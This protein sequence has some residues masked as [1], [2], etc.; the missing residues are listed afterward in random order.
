MGSRI[1]VLPLHVANK[2]AA[3]EVVDRPAS[4]VKELIENAVD[5]GATR[6]EVELEGGGRTRVS[7]T[8]NGAGMGRDDALLSIERQATSKIRD[9]DDIERIATLGFRGEALAAI[10]SVSRFRLVTR[11][12]AS[13]TATELR[14]SGGTLHDVM[15]AGGPVGTTV[16]VRDLFFNIPA[17]RKFLRSVQ[18]EQSHARHAFIL[19]ALARP[20]RAFTLTA[21]GQRAFDLPAGTRED[22]IRDLFGPDYLG[23][24]RPIETATGTI[25]VAGYAGLPSYARADRQEQYGFIN[26]RAAAAPVI[27]FAIREAY[28]GAMAKDKH[29]AVFLYITLDPAQVD[30]NVHPT[31]REV[32][33]RRPGDVRDAVLDALRAA[34]RLP[35][36][37]PAAQAEPM[38]L[39][40]SAVQARLRIDDLPE[41]RPF[42]YP[43]RL[44]PDAA[45]ADE[46]APPAPET[47]PD[48][49]AAPPAVPD[50][51]T[52]PWSWCRVLGQVGGLYVVLE[53]GEGLVLMDPHASHERVLFEALMRQYVAGRVASQSLLMPETAALSPRDAARVRANLDTLRGMGFGV[54]EFGGDAFVV[55]AVPAVLGAVPA[56]EVLAAVARDLEQAGTRGA[57]GRW[58]EDAIAQAACKA[59]VK[60][61]DRL[62]L[63]EIEQLVVDLANAEMPYTCP[64]GRPT[65]IFMSYGDLHHKFGRA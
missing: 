4:V 60:A 32:R 27:G 19:A 14:V 5:S 51:A 58:K 61:R 17:R 63:E 37:L 36:G 12:A 6:I 18:T 57:R 20:E 43:R 48:D 40:P 38:P 15:E 55:D 34:L 7:V 29:P 44:N 45:A 39:R 21:D 8:D 25:G 42:R 16:D 47:A 2:I 11:E 50:G 1:H 3:G 10:A 35:H 46:A 23:R 31:K 13:A 65:V 41:T 33:F 62:T 30:V 64:H 52:A 59:A 54:A 53:T 56:E 22:R 49:A 9:V 24:L 26:G 28:R